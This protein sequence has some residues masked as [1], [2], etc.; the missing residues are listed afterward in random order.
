MSRPWES[1]APGLRGAGGGRQPASLPDPRSPLPRLP[2]TLETLVT[3]TSPR[4]SAERTSGRR[5]PGNAGMPGNKFAPRVTCPARANPGA[6]AEAG[7]PGPKSAS[8]P[9]R[10]RAGCA[11]L[12]TVIAEGELRGARGLGLGAGRAPTCRSRRAGKHDP[13][14]TRPSRPLRG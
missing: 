11:E 13:L 3:A 8:L 9:P 12:I 10:S 4:H 7:Q 1:R 5:C 2:P 14:P 6:R